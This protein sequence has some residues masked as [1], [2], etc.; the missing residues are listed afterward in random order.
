M[1]VVVKKN[2]DKEQFENLTNWLKSLGVTLH[3]SEGE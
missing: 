2:P 1:V 3:I